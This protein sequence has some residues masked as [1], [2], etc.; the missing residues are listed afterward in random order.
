MSSFLAIIFDKFTDDANPGLAGPSLGLEEHCISYAALEVSHACTDNL[1]PAPALL[2]PF[3]F[4]RC[5]SIV[6]LGTILLL[7]LLKI[8]IIVYPFPRK[9]LVSEFVV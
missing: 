5:G 4:A 2:R 9:I 3:P 1:G 6:C 8:I 7:A